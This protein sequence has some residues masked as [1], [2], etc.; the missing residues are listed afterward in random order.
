MPIR[1]VGRP[2]RLK[3]MQDVVFP[4][5]GVMD[6][7]NLPCIWCCFKKLAAFIWLCLLISI[8][9]VSLNAS[10]LPGLVCSEQAYARWISTCSVVQE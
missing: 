6:G 7:R 5:F 8:A 1:F 3:N 2:Q 4:I 10:T 9:F